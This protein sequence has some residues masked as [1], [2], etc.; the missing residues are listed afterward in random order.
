MIFKTETLQKELNEHL[1][2]MQKVK[3]KFDMQSKEFD[4][5]KI[6]LDVV[7]E[8]L[9]ITEGKFKITE[10]ELSKTK[11][12]LK[13]VEQNYTE[14][15]QIINC[16]QDTE[17]Q[18]FQHAKEI[19]QIADEASNDTKFLQENI[20]R[21]KEKDEKALTSSNNLINSLSSQIFNMKNE[22]QHLETA[23]KESSGLIVSDLEAHMSSN[24]DYSNAVIECLKELNTLRNSFKNQ[25][26]DKFE[27]WIE[28]NDAVSKQEFQT[29]SQ[30]IRDA[31]E[32]EEIFIDYIEKKI[33]NF[34]EILS[35][36][37]EEEIKLKNFFTEK[38]N[39]QKHNN[40]EFSNY[41]QMKFDTYQ[42]QLISISSMM[43]SKNDTQRCKLNEMK[44]LLQEIED[45]SEQNTVINKEITDISHDIEGNGI[46][47]AKKF[48]ENTL[49][50]T[51]ENEVVL[52]QSS[53]V[54][55]ENFDKLQSDIK[56]TIDFITNGG[57]E[58]KRKLIDQSSNVEHVEKKFKQ[59]FNVIKE[60]ITVLT[61]EANAQNNTK[62]Q[63][64][65]ETVE[66]ETS[67]SA[68]QIQEIKSVVQ[69]SLHSIVNGL[70]EKISESCVRMTQGINEFRNE[71]VFAYKS[72][73]ETP[74]RKEYKFNRQL[75]TTSPHDRIIRRYRLEQG[76]NESSL[77][78]I[79]ILEVSFCILL[80]I[81]SKH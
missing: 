40:N 2:A 48:I 26:F 73:G 66:K 24:K 25:L 80:I 20:K 62:E 12:N 55:N 38:I 64:L 23:H 13:K 7:S 46:S 27:K 72:T 60:A 77:Q 63:F 59:Q 49:K 57:N 33:S 47:V 42:K 51:H 32:K 45:I 54:L 3:E 15:K 11:R 76:L 37:K 28:E 9:T 41:M 19:I 58:K 53:S 71:N 6:S 21:R 31:Q 5:C 56:T 43:K 22:V 39:E 36:R 16:H 79:S 29:M 69:H 18:L 4:A 75:T 67:R 68:I 8:Q 52:S 70:E 14:A 65:T 17:Q 30:F 50:T 78:D 81:L 61:N 1:Q 35:Q 34:M 10:T 44:K 74:A